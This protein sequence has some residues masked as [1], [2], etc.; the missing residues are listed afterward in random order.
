MF[1][2]REIEELI[3]FRKELHANPELSGQEKETAQRVIAFLE[4]C[5]PSKIISSVGGHG[6][7]AVYDSGNK[8]L[9]LLIR[10]DMDALPIKEINDFKH[11]SKIDGVSH[12]C[13]HDG[14]TTI[15]LGLAKL[16]SKNPPKEGKALLLFQPAEE[17]GAGAA[18]VL[19]DEKFT[20]LKPDWVFGLHNLPGFPLHEVVIRKD[21]FTASVV[22]LVIDLNGKTA[23][24]AEPEHGIN[25]SSAISELLL[26]ASIW[27]NNSPKRKDF[28]VVTPVHVNLGSEA[29]GTSAGEAKLGF[30]IRTW[31][32]EEMEKLKAKIENFL[33][34]LAEKHLLKLNYKY[35]EEFKACENHHEAIEQIK[36]VA[37]NLKLKVTE[38]QMPFKWGEDFGLYTQSYKGAFFGLGAGK[39]QPALHNP[40]YDFPDELLPTGSNMFYELCK[41]YLACP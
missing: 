12:K 6:V 8:G 3:T 31:T 11:R 20:S 7:V 18:A 32:E 36:K 13:G 38:P 19:S 10:G 41:N 2:S 25:P 28:A 4:E 33:I 1:D 27:S 26:Q 35:I 40:D 14:H 39:D 30:T 24:A 16:L 34:T 15:L 29:Y 23:H 22:S 17:I 9:N 21:S 5:S 37:E